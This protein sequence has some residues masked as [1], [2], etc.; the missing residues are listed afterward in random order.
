MGVLIFLGIV[1]V[2]LAGTVA[3]APH[4][5]RLIYQ[6]NLAEIAQHEAR[7]QKE[8]D[9]YRK[10]GGYKPMKM[11]RTEF[12]AMRIARIEGAWWALVWPVSLTY[13]RL[14]GTA[15]AA[16]IAAQKA[17]ANTRIIKDYE[18]LLQE[19]FDRELASAA[20]ISP[21]TRIEKIRQRT[22]RK[23]NP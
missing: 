3:S 11:H 9:E 20:K 13:H 2:Y 6:D 17:T 22:T 10:G 19:S 1:T 5:M 18:L 12:D 7:Y 4:L 14:A 8:M 23:E 15:F 21:L 16:E